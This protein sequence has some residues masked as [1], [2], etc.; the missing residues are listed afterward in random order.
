MQLNA[1]GEVGTTVELGSSGLGTE[2]ASRV[3]LNEVAYGINFVAPGFAVVH[4]G[5]FY[6]RIKD[7]YPEHRDLFPIGKPT[8]FADQIQ[9]PALPRVWFENGT[10]LIQLQMDRFVYNWRRLGEE[11]YPGFSVLSLEFQHELEGFLAFAAEAFSEPLHFDELNLTYVNHIEDVDSL[12]SPIF[13]FRENDWRKEF[14]EPEHVL[15]QYRFEFKDENMRLTVSARPAIQL[16]TQKR[17]TQFDLT[18]QTL[19][20]PDISIPAARSD[21]FESAHRKIHW[22]FQ[23]LIR[24]E[25]RAQWGFVNK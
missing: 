4:Y 20:C 16:D 24:E 1:S 17:V 9:I 5:Q 6:A 15:N 25:W 11:P 3:P 13:V 18:L 22:S 14:P 7:R 21:W 2:P 8:P 10:R 12:K 19:K 23:R